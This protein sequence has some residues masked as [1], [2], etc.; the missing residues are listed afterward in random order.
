V[1]GLIL[2]DLGY[3]RLPRTRRSGD[4]YKSS[5]EAIIDVS[6]PIPVRRSGAQ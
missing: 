6:S 2:E 5:H 4:N 1:R 3:R